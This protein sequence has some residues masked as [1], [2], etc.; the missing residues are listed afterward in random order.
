M[1]A[2]ID[3]IEAGA[4]ADLAGKPVLDAAAPGRRALALLA[5]Q[6]LVGLALLS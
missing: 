4:A 5:A 3:E 6:V 1:S 2:R